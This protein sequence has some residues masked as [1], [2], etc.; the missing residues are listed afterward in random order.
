MRPLSPYGVYHLAYITVATVNADAMARNKRM[1]VTP[2]PV[3][4]RALP[5]WIRRL[6]RSAQA[7]TRESNI[8]PV[9]LVQPGAP[10]PSAGILPDSPLYCRHLYIVASILRGMAHHEIA[11]DVVVAGAGNGA[12][13][14]ALSA[15][16]EG[17]SVVVLENAPPSAQG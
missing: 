11:Y 1:F 10:R 3:G 14:A 4:W 16:D 5:A 12:L 6:R 2:T 9:A 8:T 15:R 13:C 7:L 17:A